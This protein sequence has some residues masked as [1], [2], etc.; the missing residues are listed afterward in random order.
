[1]I[2]S[3]NTNYIVK[4]SLHV[5]R[6][7]LHVTQI[8]LFIVF[9]LMTV[10]VFF[11]T[12]P[13]HAQAQ[14]RPQVG[15]GGQFQEGTAVTV[16]KSTKTIAEY[17]R[18]IYKYMIGAVG[19]LAAVVMMVGGIIWLTAGGNPDKIGQ[20]KE[21]IGGSML[22][23]VIAFGAYMILATINP[24]LVNFKIREI[25]D[26][27]PR[28]LDV[29][30]PSTASISQCCNNT[31]GPQ[32]PVNNSCPSGSTPCYGKEYCSR[33]VLGAGYTCGGGAGELPVGP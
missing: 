33:F 3:S 24:D 12:A 1:M 27:T 14:F 16:S 7:T 29:I 10:S 21:W 19:I 20:A 26:I 32:S 4:T 23:L 31:L 2:F 6:Y 15:V 5:T 9:L 22:G 30:N 11:P 18:E 28:G 17:L 8:A 13:A 25:Q